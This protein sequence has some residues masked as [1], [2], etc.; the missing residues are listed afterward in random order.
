MYSVFLAVSFSLLHGL[1]GNITGFQDTLQGLQKLHDSS[2]KINFDAVKNYENLIASPQIQKSKIKIATLNQEEMIMGQI[3]SMED[4]LKEEPITKLE[5]EEIKEGLVLPE[6]IMEVVTPEKQLSEEE[7]AKK[8]KEEV[9]DTESSKTST[10]LKEE[11]IAPSKPELPII[12]E[13]EETKQNKTAKK[14]TLA[15][16]LP[17]IKTKTEEVKKTETPK[18]P[19]PAEVKKEDIAKAEAEKERQSLSKS[20]IEASTKTTPKTATVKT[21]KEIEAEAKAKTEMIQ[22]IKEV[23]AEIRFYQKI[24]AKNFRE[25]S[26]KKIP[27]IVPQKKV[28]RVFVT[29]DVPVELESSYRSRKNRHIPR[30]FTEQEKIDMLYY[31]IYKNNAHKIKSFANYFPNIN[32]LKKYGET[33][34]TYATLTER[35]SAMYVLLFEGSDINQKNDIGQAPIHIVAKHSDIKGAAILIQNK[36][37]LNIVDSLKRSALMYAVM[38]EDINMAYMLLESG[39]NPNLKDFKGKTAFY[40]AKVNDDDNMQKMLVKYG[41][42]E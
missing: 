19:T 11:E 41:A 20:K 3:E 23:A 28:Q 40:M 39:A 13:V 5:K 18:V 42:R 37:E 33:P 16:Q 30:Y 15:P 22:A 6:E 31:N 34:L 9:K 17:I 14:E 27:M 12:K 8:I 7:L 38:N 25:E 32:L 4:A 2:F 21:A 26:D 1:N 29:S 24:L 36:S 35:H 10:F